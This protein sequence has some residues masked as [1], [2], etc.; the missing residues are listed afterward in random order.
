MKIKILLNFSLKLADQVEYIA[1]DKPTAAKTFKREVLNA[2]KGIGGMPYKNRKSI[3]YEDENIR[4]LIFKGYKII[5]RIKSDK[6]IL[7]VFGFIKQEK[8]L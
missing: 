5:Y 7:E 8:T 1:R 3:Y 4:E 6:N 2:I